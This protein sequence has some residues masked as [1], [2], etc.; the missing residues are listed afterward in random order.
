MKSCDVLTELYNLNI[1]AGWKMERR[2]EREKERKERKV[3]RENEKER[4]RALDE[5]QR[6]KELLTQGG[7]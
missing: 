3:G 4:R 2:G 7:E 1:F 6:Q 5:L